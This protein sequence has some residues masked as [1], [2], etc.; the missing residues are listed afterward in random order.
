MK[1]Q[2]A[3]TK[4][5]IA[6]LQANPSASYVSVAR[7]FKM[8]S[9]YVYKLRS[10]MKLLTKSS[11]K[12]EA[13]NTLMPLERAD[14]IRLLRATDRLRLTTLKELNS[15][16]SDNVNHPPHYKIGGIETIDFIEAKSL[17]YNLGNVIKYVSRADHK[18]SRD[19]DLQKALWY[20]NREISKLNK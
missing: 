19:E 2:S 9:S 13:V 3:K 12:V 11:T 16:N 6:Y 5:V 4:K 18:G 7:K 1:T 10:N 8:S 14:R 15:P 17:G 20:L